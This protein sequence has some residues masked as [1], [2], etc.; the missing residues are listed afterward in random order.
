[1]KENYKGLF[2]RKGLKGESIV[3]SLVF[4][5]V[6]FENQLPLAKVDFRKMGVGFKRGVDFSQIE[7]I[8]HRNRLS[9]NFATTDNENFFCFRTSFDGLFQRADYYTAFRLVVG[10]A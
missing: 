10:L 8:R 2:S 6:F 9:V 7:F 3:M 5:M 1:M 4:R